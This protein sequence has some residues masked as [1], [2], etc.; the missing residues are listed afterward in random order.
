MSAHTHITH[1]ESDGDFDGILASDPRPML[2]EF[3]AA[4]CVPCQRMG[5]KVAAFVARHSTQVRL[6]IVDG[7]VCT[8]TRNRFG[9]SG[10][11]SMALV[12]A[13]G[14]DVLLLGGRGE[15]QLESELLPYVRAAP[16]G[17]PVAPPEAPP[18]WR[19]GR[20]ITITEAEGLTVKLR[21]KEERT[22]DVGRHEVPEDSS[23]QVIL[24][25]VEEAGVLSLAHLAG[26]ESSIDQLVVGGDLSTDEFEI[27]SQC[28]GLSLLALMRTAP[29]QPSDIEVLSNLTALRTLI[30]RGQ[31]DQLAEEHLGRA[32]PHC[33]INGRWVSEVALRTTG[34]LPPAPDEAVVEPFLAGTLHIGENLST[35]I[36]R[37]PE[38]GYVYGPGSTDG[39]PLR[40][41]SL[42]DDSVI[43]LPSAEDHLT[44]AVEFEL[45]RTDLSAGIAAEAQFCTSEQC[46][47]PQTL[48]CL[49]T[50][51]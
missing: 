24:R 27:L 41:R 30:A 32:L 4:W 5:P 45:H 50:H 19:T 7:D 11:P 47:M 34:P 9:I 49:P 14:V 20:T 42:G 35:F 28:T 22:L 6:A 39:V 15:G 21:G 8:T 44:G 26:W 46:F 16:S 29:L 48:W 43:E 25:P 51:A 1:V 31:I 38:G 33:T 40:L 23:V 37:V 12:T 3:T 17:M 10:F 2:L 13:R 18:F 36:L